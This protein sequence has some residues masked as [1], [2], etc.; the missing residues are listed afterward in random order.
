M[1][2]NFFSCHHCGRIRTPA[3]PVFRFVPRRESFG[4]QTTSHTGK[5]R[6]V[7]SFCNLNLFKSVSW[8]WEF[9]LCPSGSRQG[10]SA[11]R[12]TGGAGLV[13]KAARRTESGYPPRLHTQR[14]RMKHFYPSA[15][16]AITHLAHTLSSLPLR[17]GSGRWQSPCQPVCSWPATTHFPFFCVNT[18]G[19]ISTNLSMHGFQFTHK[20]PVSAPFFKSMPSP[21]SPK[22]A[23]PHVSSLW[24]CCSAVGNPFTSPG[25]NTFWGSSTRLVVH[26][27]D[28]QF[29]PVYYALNMADSLTHQS[30]Y[31]RQH[32]AHFE[33]SV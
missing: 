29:Y 11:A 32:R 15:S 14:I 7:R 9:T 21:L 19:L 23:S 10:V 4:Y 24:P 16:S 33:H 28:R 1:A 17:Q 27:G 18:V 12:N 3:L 25:L 31:H 13:P 5:P 26:D 30:L 22:A 8:C 20:R 6:R 2:F